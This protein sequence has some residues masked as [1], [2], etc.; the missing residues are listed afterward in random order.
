MTYGPM[1]A[2]A[3]GLLSSGEPERGLEGFRAAYPRVRTRLV[4]QREEFDGSLHHA[5]L[6]KDGDGATISL[7]R[8]A[9]RALPWPL[10]GVHRA[11][12][13]LL[14]RVNGVETPVARAIAC[15]D[16]IW[17]ES[18]LADRLVADSL[19]REELEETREPLSDAALQEA[20]DAFRRARGL[21]TG[22]A[23]RAWMERNRISHR[24][25]EELVALEA[26]VAALRSRVA[27]GRV[28][29]WF[30]E[31]GAQLDVAR[32]ARA[33]FVTEPAAVPDAAGFLG[34]VERA[35][36]DGSARPGEVFATVRRGD[37][38]GETAERI[39]GAPPGTVA[40]PFPVEGGH[41][42]VKVLAVEP[43]VL[44]ATVR[45]LVERRIFSEW[46]DERRNAAKIE[47]FWG[48][49]ERTAGG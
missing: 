31:H 13:H 8:C 37:L 29:D 23:T 34:A 16:F 12:E 27:E 36:A 45:D 41:L 17:D 3:V 21:L 22:E 1:L 25:L 46:I 49:A 35:F 39:F 48:I 30:A 20:M 42:L 28:E 26:A 40:G 44:D 32:V 7:S 6:I 43:A 5:L 2:D 14:L 24:E 38:D 33:V 10:R 19:V 47:W 15:L 9:E 4:A 11:G 18:A